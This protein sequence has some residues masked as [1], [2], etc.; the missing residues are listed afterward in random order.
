MPPRRRPRLDGGQCGRRSRWP[1]VRRAQTCAEGVP[2][3]WRYPK[4]EMVR[5]SARV[6]MWVSSGARTPRSERWSVR[7]GGQGIR[8]PPGFATTADAF[9]AYL[10]ANRLNETIA[11]T[12]A[13][14]E[15]GKLTLHE[16]GV[17]DPGRHGRRR[18][19][20]RYRRRHPGCL[21]RARAAHGTRR[22]GRGRPLQRD[23][24]GP[25]GRELRRPAGDIP[26]RPRRR[27]AA[28][29]LPAL[30]R[31]ALH[32]PRD[33]LPAAEGVRPRQGGAV[34]RRAADGALRSRRRRA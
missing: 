4:R 20:R 24:R 34:G 29:R 31:V 3:A 13:R 12:L 18:L 23:R 26:E 33:H 21:S 5:G 19:A 11:E 17:G 28:R 2:D 9:R 22:A 7:L 6:P 25:A 8:V 27:G 32:R 16:A 14:L 10:A 15:A 30:L 1:N